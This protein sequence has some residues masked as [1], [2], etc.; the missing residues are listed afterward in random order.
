MKKNVFISLVFISSLVLN[1]TSL[2]LKSDR[3]QPAQIE[4]DD[5]EIN[6]QTGVRT[7]TNNVIVVQ[8]TLRLKA[9]KLVA[10]YDKQGELVRAVADG[11][12]ARFKQRPDGKP[13]DVEGWAKNIYVDYPNNTITL[14]GKAALKQG[15][16]TATG[17]KIVYNMATDVLNIVGDSIIDTAGK[18]GEAPKRKLEDPFADDVPSPNT[19]IPKAAVKKTNEVTTTNKASEIAEEVIET[20]VE[21]AKQGRSRL[22]LQPKK[23]N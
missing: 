11:S 3:D 16:S 6:F 7:L 13:D 12:L 23:K 2:A 8:G 1:S 17:N 18:N 21:P 14:T 22:I 10:T 20:Q 19:G 4:A 9:D 15:G 5:T